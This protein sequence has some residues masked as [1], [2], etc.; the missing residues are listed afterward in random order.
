M[1]GCLEIEALDALHLDM[2][3]GQTYH[4]WRIAP[5]VILHAA[6]SI[7]VAMIT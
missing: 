5:T 1:V 6:T 7:A 3:T 4:I 2:G